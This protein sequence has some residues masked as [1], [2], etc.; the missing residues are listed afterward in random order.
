MSGSLTDSVLPPGMRSGTEPPAAANTHEPNPRP[1]LF[2]PSRCGRVEGRVT[3]KPEQFRLV[4][5]GVDC[6]LIH[7]RTGQRYRLI[8]TECAVERR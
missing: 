6:V 8:E 2:D 7:Q 5:S 1:A 4:R 3:E